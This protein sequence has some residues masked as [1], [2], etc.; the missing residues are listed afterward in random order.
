M[1]RFKLNTL[2][3]AAFSLLVLWAVTGFVLLSRD[4]IDASTA[5]KAEAV[6]KVLIRTG[7]ESAALRQIAQPFEQETGIKVQF[8]EVGRDSY[9]TAVGTQLFAGSN[10]FDVVLM[11]S[12]SIAQFASS[13][14]ILP[15]DRYIAMS[16]SASGEP[17]DIDDFLSVYRYNGSIYALPTDISTHFLYY[18]SD[19]IPKPP[20][21]WDELYEIAKTFTA[22]IHRNSPTR[23]GLVMPAVVPEEREK[24]F[25]SILW[26]FGG[27]IIGDDGQVLFDSKESIQSG[28]Y[29]EKL[30]R[31]SVVPGDLMSWDFARTRD[32][33]IN[34][35][36]AMA[37]PYWNSAYP[38]IAQSSSPHK[39]H[40]RIALIPGVRDE[41]GQVRRIPFQ[42]GWTLSINASSTNQLGAW[43]FV[44]FATGKQGGMIYARNGGIPARRS[45]LSAPEFRESRPDFALILK[46]L[47]I[48][49]SEPSLIYY[50]AMA[51]VQENALAKILTLFAS[52]SDAFQDAAAE[53]RNLSAHISVKV[54]ERM[55]NNP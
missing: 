39:D 11:P 38:M 53:L 15:L 4:M 44:E 9:F 24:I 34:G 13:K 45:I 23:W 40:I 46:S 36:V 42:H 19:L 3:A 21:T 52:P 16:G 6:V 30:M 7:T 14:A 48:A 10:T 29:L 43:K 31:E 49:R 32:A 51:E 37:A 1:N 35:D 26:S 18:R 22:G 28:E 17:V 5:P 41:T 12:T 47:T 33:L 8:I 20:E 27:N 55:G 2:M 50:P 54:P 25:D